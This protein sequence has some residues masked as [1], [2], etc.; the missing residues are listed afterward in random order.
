LDRFR[1]AQFCPIA[2]AAEILGQRWMLLVF[3]ELF[4][5]PRRFSDLR[6]RLRGMSS[7]VL[8]E[9]LASLEQAGLV[10]RR[11]LPPPSAA[12]VYELTADGRA[13]EPALLEITRWGLRLMTPPRPGEQLEPEWVRLGVRAFARR[14]AGPA[15]RFELRMPAEPEPISVRVAGGAEGTTVLDDDAPVDASVTAPPL[16]ILGLL[17]GGLDPA[18]ALRDGAVVVAGDAAALA[19]LPR[20]FDVLPEPEVLSDPP[21]ADADASEAH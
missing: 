12:S 20:L 4:G 11:V 10:G 5:G 18:Q 3:R 9:R 15:R 17:S 6:R 19:D 13:F 2:R 14:S 21:A 1:Y 8:A 7:S 16:V